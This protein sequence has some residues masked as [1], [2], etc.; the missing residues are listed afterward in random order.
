MNQAR[1]SNFSALCPWR[2][3]Y[4]RPY[5]EGNERYAHPEM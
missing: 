1:P 4:P 2:K 3:N 5:A